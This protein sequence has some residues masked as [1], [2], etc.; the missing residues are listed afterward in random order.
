MIYR[1]PVGLW[2]RLLA[3]LYPSHCL[4]CGTLVP[5]DCLF[6]SDCIPDLPEAPLLREFT[7]SDGTP[8]PVLAPMEYREGFRATMLDYKFH[9][10][11]Q[12]SVPLGFLMADTVPYFLREEGMTLF[13]DF[14]CISYVPL[15]QKNFQKRGYDQSELLAKQVSRTLGLP[16]RRLLEKSQQSQTQHTLS[17]AERLTNLKG[18]YSCVQ[19]AEGLSVFLVDDIVT[20]GSTLIECA[21]VLY[22]AG[23][24]LVVGLCAASSAGSGEALIEPID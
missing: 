11:F 1:I 17:R 3:L 15:H 10:L 2:Q 5:P 8:L 20:T 18:V 22:K 6:C 21:S 13:Q 24:K 4:S 12:L 14:S 9:G 7:L 19:K 23:A 16:I